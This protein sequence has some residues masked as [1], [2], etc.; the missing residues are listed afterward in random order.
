[1]RGSAPIM[2]WPFDESPIE[3]RALSAHGGNETWMAVLPLGTAR[4]SWMDV[5]TDFA[6]GALSEHPQDNG[7]TVVIGAGAP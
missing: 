6:P 1:M 2:A 4:P 3:F 7:T 5:G